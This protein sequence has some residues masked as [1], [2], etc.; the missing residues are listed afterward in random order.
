[1]EMGEAEGPDRG[2][3]DP[4]GMQEQL[5]LMLQDAAQ[6]AEESEA[7]R[8]S[9]SARANL[10]QQFQRDFASRLQ[11]RCSPTQTQVRCW[12]RQQL[13]I[14]DL[15]YGSDSEGELA[16]Q[17]PEIQEQQGPQ[18]GR[19]SGARQRQQQQQQGLRR[20]SR[21]NLGRMGDAF[22]AVHGTTMGCAKGNTAGSRQPGGKGGRGGTT[23]QPDTQ[24][25]PPTPAAAPPPRRRRG[26]GRGT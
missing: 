5:E 16:E 3:A 1:V 19:Q 17:P 10:Q 22:A 20:S 26:G 6:L 2:P 21:S 24:H 23:S 8:L 13:A 7:G 18:R 4:T 15:G 11:A 25:L 14:P 12:I 9:A